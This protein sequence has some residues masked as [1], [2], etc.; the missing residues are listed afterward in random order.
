MAYLCPS[1]LLTAAL[2][3][4]LSTPCRSLMPA[5][6]KLSPL[7]ETQGRASATFLSMSLL[8]G[9]TDGG[10]PPN[11]RLLVSKGMKAFSAGDVS[12]SIEL[13]DQ[14]ERAAPSLTPYLWQRGLSYYYADRFREGSE[15]FRTDVRVN[16]LDVEEIVWD[17]AC[18]A[19]VDP[20]AAF[21]PE[22]K[23]SLPPGKKDRRKIMSTVYS[24][25]RGDGATEQALFAAG[26]DGSTSDEFYSLFYLGLYCECRDETEKA[27]SYMRSA[28]KTKYATGLGAGD[29]MTS[30]A[31][32]HCKLRGWS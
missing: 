5:I 14:A 12:G 31:R 2:L 20:G 22:G 32:I 16:P 15:Q 3:L 23:M 26:H 1:L 29:Y 17:I 7:G 11:P 8:D 27:A 28:T 10:D 6:T 24:L 30:C 21:P 18:L 13:F 9:A 25:F 4:V 19:R